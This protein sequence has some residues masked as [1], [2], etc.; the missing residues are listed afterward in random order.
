MKN[1][2]KNIS[3]DMEAFLLK[4]KLLSEQSREANKIK[5][6]LIKNANCEDEFNFYSTRPINYFLVHFVYNKDNK[7]ITFDTFWNWK[8][9]GYNI[10]KGEKAFALWGKP[11]YIGINTNNL[12]NDFDI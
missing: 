6:E 9:N 12:I 4:R 2:N 11:K 10:K 3:K 1:E 7:E 8:K 5:E